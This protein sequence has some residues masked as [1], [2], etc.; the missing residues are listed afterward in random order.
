MATSTDSVPWS[1]VLLV[2]ALLLLP[3][4]VML[5]AMP[6]VG[7]GMMSGARVSP[8]VALVSGLVPLVVLV[9]VGYLVYRAFAGGSLPGGRDPAVEELRVAFARGDVSREEFEERRELLEREE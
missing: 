2:L 8:A 3:P 4:L 1:L 6:M 5:L 9:G 7:Y